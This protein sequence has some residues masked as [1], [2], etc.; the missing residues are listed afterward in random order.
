[1]PDKRERDLWWAFLE[2]RPE[3]EWNITKTSKKKQKKQGA[4]QIGMRG[5]ADEPEQ[6]E[7]SEVIIYE[8]SLLNDEG[9]VEEV[10]RVDPTELLPTPSGTPAP[11][12]RD[13]SMDDAVV[14]D[15]PILTPREPTTKLIKEIDEVSRR[16]FHKYHY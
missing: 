11:S 1:M 4:R 12:D 6:E 5:W 3:S 10:L 15:I 13:T 16:L 2:G 9:E 14:S 8:S 7:I